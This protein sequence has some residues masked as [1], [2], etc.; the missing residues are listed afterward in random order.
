MNIA[1]VANNWHTVAFNSTTTTFSLTPTTLTHGAAQNF[2][3]Q[4]SAASGTPTGDVSIIASTLTATGS[5][6]CSR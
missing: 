5:P 6:M 4:V 3:I 2:S 1:N